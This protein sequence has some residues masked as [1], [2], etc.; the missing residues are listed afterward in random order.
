MMAREAS[1]GNKA[2][3]VPDTSFQVRGHCSSLFLPINTPSRTPNGANRQDRK[4]VVDIWLSIKASEAEIRTKTTCNPS[5][6]KFTT[7]LTKF[8][9]LK[10]S[11]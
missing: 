4:T 9:W 8:T 5:L 11:K 1:T 6:K 7:P 2:H 10:N 3:L